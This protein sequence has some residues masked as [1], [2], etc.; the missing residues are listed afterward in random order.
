MDKPFKSINDQIEILESRNL[1]IANHESAKNAL[2][3]YGYYEVVN[4]YKDLFMV[5]N[6]DPDGFIPGT[7]FEH[8]ESLYQLDRS[9]RY[10]VVEALETLEANIRQAV[11]YV[12]AENISEDQRVYIDRNKYNTGKKYQKRYNGRMHD[13][14][15][16]DDLVFKMNK[17]SESDSQP[18]KHYRTKYGNVPPW[19]LV[20]EMPFGTLI[21]FFQLLKKAEKTK[22]LSILT[23]QSSNTINGLL[24]KSHFKSAFKELLL[25]YLTYRNHASH[26][27]RTYN[28]STTKYELSYNEYIHDFIGVTQGDYR[29]K[30]GRSRVGVV[31]KTLQLFSD[32]PPYDYLRAHLKVYLSNYFKKFPDDQEV[33][34]RE[35]ELDLSDIMS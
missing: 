8:L 32:P 29:V 24:E 35:M 33:I 10:G 6:D 16:I 19:I 12:V 1:I 20:K 22:V 18:I 2:V 11:A 31:L 5:S 23:G 9:V 13:V 17:I 28:F 7:T 30:R 25:L 21:W 4:G 34:L 14:W 15:L 27:G 3:R 26:G